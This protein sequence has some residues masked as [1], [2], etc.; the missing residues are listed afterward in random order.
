MKLTKLFSFSLVVLALL[1]V[2]GAASAQTTP[3]VTY[4]LVT[5]IH[6]PANP[7]TGNPGD[8]KGGN[9]I[10][11]FDPAT[12]RYYIA[13]SG[14]TKGSGQIDVIDAAQLKYLFSIPGFTGRYA[15]IASSG[16]TGVIVIPKRQELWTGDGD[17]TTKVI[18]LTTNKIVSTIDVS[19]PGTFVGNNGLKTRAD[20][21][22]YDPADGILL[23]T[24]PDADVPY[25]AFISVAT[26]QVLGYHLFPEAVGGGIEQPAFSPLTKQFYINVIGPTFLNIEQIDPNTRLTNRIYPTTC[27]SRN[28]GLVLL[29]F[30]KLVTSCGIVMD[31]RTGKQITQVT[32]GLPQLLSSA[33]QIWYNPGDNRVY[34]GGRNLGVVDA[35]TNAFLGFIAPGVQTATSAGGHSVAVDSYTNYVFVPNSGGIKVYA[36][37]K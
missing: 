35:E 13:D 1:A 12:Q 14:P 33:D 20:E 34:F 30:Q 28:A 7:D 21:I 25:A 26:R 3:T 22:A 8:L 11:W 15:G 32:S 24:I 18:D 31:A 5:T 16:P 27:T 29:P 37:S 6:I 10:S 4:N 9:D 17:A 36:Q 2:A 19:S 23:I